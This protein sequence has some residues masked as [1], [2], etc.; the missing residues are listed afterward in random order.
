MCLAVISGLYFG[1]IRI[2]FSELFDM[3]AQGPVAAVE[4]EIKY[5]LVWRL[6]MPR[7]LSALMSGA[8]LASSGV[9]FQAVLRNPL[10]EPYTLGVASGAAFGASVA[11]FAGLRWITMASFAG[12]MAA[13]CAVWALGERDGTGDDVSGV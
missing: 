13:L 12:S 4:E 1:E 2:T 9:I 10:A 7:V 3:L 6:R 11:I 5:G 8:I